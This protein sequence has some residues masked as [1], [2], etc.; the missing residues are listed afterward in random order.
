MSFPQ[1]S[2]QKNRRKRSSRSRSI[3]I[4][5]IIMLAH[6]YGRHQ[7]KVSKEKTSSQKNLRGASLLTTTSIATTTSSSTYLCALVSNNDFFIPTTLHRTYIL[8]PDQAGPPLDSPHHITKIYKRFTILLNNSF[9]RSSG[10]AWRVE[11]V[12]K[13]N[14]ISV[15]ASYL[16]INIRFCLLT[17]LVA[18]SPSTTKIKR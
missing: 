16:T 5:I 14:N 15:I 8:T 11:K 9:V 7:T 13:T 10:L 18:F 12:G 6:Y 2:S 3:I 4:I 1:L 17:W